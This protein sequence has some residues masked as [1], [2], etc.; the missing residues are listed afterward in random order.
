MQV[1]DPLLKRQLEKAI[2]HN[3]QYQQ[4]C[5]V[6]LEVFQV[7]GSDDAGSTNSKMCNVSRQSEAQN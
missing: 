3:G 1:R 7:S 4:T 5:V 6:I 2:K